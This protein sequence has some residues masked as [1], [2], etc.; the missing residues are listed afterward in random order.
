MQKLTISIL[1]LLVVA[2]ALAAPPASGVSPHH[3]PERTVLVFVPQKMFREDVLE[4]VRRRLEYAGL[5]VRITSPDTT[6]AV[7]M[8]RTVIRPNLTLEEVRPEDF[9]ALILIGGSGSILHWDDTLLHE[10]SRGFAAAGKLVGAIGVAPI[11]LARAGVLKDHKA[12][13]FPHRAAVAELQ[14]GGA[15]YLANPVV[16]DANIITASDSR[17]SRRFARALSAWL[18][19]RQ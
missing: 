8:T 9:A 1:I 7:G 2:S 10:K 19:R 11:T 14:Q 16:E 12:A 6:V 4:Q 3:D 18:D 13:V 5:R 15:T 17:Y